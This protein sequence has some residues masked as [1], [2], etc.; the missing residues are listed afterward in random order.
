MKQL[1]VLLCFPVVL[2][3]CGNNGEK[4]EKLSLPPKPGM[5][6][7][8]LNIIKEKNY[9]A[10]K[11]A[12]LSPFEMDAANPYTWFDELKDTASFTK[13]FLKENLAMK[14]QFKND[15]G[16]ALIDDN[17]KTEA[18]YKLDTAVRDEEKS[19]IKLRISYPDS[20]MN[21]P[22]ITEPMIMTYTFY[23]LGINEKELLLETPRSYNNRKVI[24]LFNSK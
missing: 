20:S 12:T 13:D 2:F 4:T 15:T 24:I 1:F 21:F 5:V 8:V 16:V 7:E 18:I 23:I 10:V 6:N 3:S 22:G 19:G 14:L 11:I 9:S 17:K